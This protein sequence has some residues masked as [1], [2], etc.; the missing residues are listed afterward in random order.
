MRGHRHARQVLA[1]REWAQVL[2]EAINPLQPLFASDT[3]LEGK[4]QWVCASIVPLS[5]FRSLGH[6]ERPVFA[7]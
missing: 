1:F 5:G 3:L 7:Y 2:H 6:T 4:F